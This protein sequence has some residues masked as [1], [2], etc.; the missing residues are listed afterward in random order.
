MGKARFYAVRVAATVTKYGHDTYASK[1]WGIMKEG[2]LDLLRNA[3]PTTMG[4]PATP[5]LR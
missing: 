5:G 3:D 1:N 4:R 2:E